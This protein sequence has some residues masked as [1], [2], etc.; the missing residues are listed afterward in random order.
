MNFKRIIIAGLAIDAVS[1]L[2]FPLFFSRPLFGWIFEL[3]PTSIWKWTPH[4]SLTS[5][6]ITW[7]TFFILA[8]TILAIFIVF[9]YA[10]LY[11]AIPGTGI[12]KG[13]TFG[14]L[15][16]PMS[17]LIPMFS[18]WAMFRVAEEAVLLFTL[19]QLIEILVYGAIIGLIYK[20]RLSP[21]L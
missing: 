18:I 16:Y 14:L 17:V 21:K 2:I 10:V 9:L 19:E 7:L 13:L 3:E 12:K 4:V 20:E 6:P 11:K 8:N 15:M 5:M 1:F